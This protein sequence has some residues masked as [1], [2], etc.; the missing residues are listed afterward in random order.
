MATIF[1]IT[2]LEKDDAKNSFDGRAFGWYPE[3]EKAQEAVIANA[4]DMNEEGHYP[5]IVVEEYSPGIHC[6]VLKEWWYQWQE[7][8]FTSCQ[9]PDW[10]LKVTNWALG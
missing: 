8:A 6:Q 9:K 5:W 2:A 3:L 1:V 10:A 4:L 7:G